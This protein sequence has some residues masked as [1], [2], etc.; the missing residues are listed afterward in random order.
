MEQNQD[1]NPI[2]TQLTKLFLG[3]FDHF[4]LFTCK[5]SNEF[6]LEPPYYYYP[7]LFSDPPLLQKVS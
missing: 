4:P 6:A 5:V 1:G 3:E 7:I 2:C